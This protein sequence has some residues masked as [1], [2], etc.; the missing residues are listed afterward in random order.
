[1]APTK[2]RYGRRMIVRASRAHMLCSSS[3]RRS[4]RRFGSEAH[5]VE[6]VA[7]VVEEDGQQRHGAQD[8]HER[9]RQRDAEPAHERDR[10]EE[11]EREADGDRA[12]R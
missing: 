6:A 2:N 10:H 1:M 7:E 4:I 12:C 3:S 11:E 5:A 8:G 9:D